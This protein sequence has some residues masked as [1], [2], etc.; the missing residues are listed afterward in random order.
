MTGAEPSPEPCPHCMHGFGV[1]GRFA[2]GYY[3]GMGK[4]GTVR[5]VV[6]FAVSTVIA[7]LLGFCV[8][9]VVMDYQGRIDADGVL[10][11]VAAM[12]PTHHDARNANSVSASHDAGKLAAMRVDR[13]RNA[14][15]PSNKPGKSSDE[16]HHG[17]YYDCFGADGVLQLKDAVN[18][19]GDIP[20]AG[21]PSN[22]QSSDGGSVSDG[23][24]AVEGVGMTVPTPD[25]Q[26]IMNDVSQYKL[27][28]DLNECAASYRYNASRMNKEDY[29]SCG[30]GWYKDA[31]GTLTAIY[32]DQNGNPATVVQNMKK[33]Q[34]D[35]IASSVDIRT[36]NRTRAIMDYHDIIKDGS[37]SDV[38]SCMK[39]HDYDVDEAETHCDSYGAYTGRDADDICALMP[40]TYGMVKD[41]VKS[42][43]AVNV[44]NDGK[45]L[46]ICAMDKEKAARK[47]AEAEARRKDEEARRQAEADK[48]VLDAD[49]HDIRSIDTIVNEV[50]EGKY[51]NG[52]ERRNL[53][54]DRYGEVQAK[55]NQ[56]CLVDKDPRCVINSM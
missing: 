15:L 20:Q 32:T 21:S 1:I 4:K 19:D 16:T 29:A 25:M 33:T 50:I 54:G 43:V 37:K 49:G 34:G 36:A 52:D 3:G 35:G 42:G 45:W 6:L 12:L 28:K 11:R 39:S 55:V 13:N 38:L 31:D 46:A 14:C 40:N 26:L 23:K 47:Q 27:L 41:G 56:Q 44:S 51:A 7:L 10:G 17:T 48:P 24:E 9:F 18:P 30:L 8:W 5:S 2:F 53:L 22:R